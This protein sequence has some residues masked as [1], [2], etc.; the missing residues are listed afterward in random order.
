[1]STNDTFIC[2]RCRCEAPGYAR[3][4]QR[5]EFCFLCYETDEERKEREAIVEAH[6]SQFY[7]M[8]A[9]R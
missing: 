1:M 8:E 2:E 4:H 7:W 9:R 3:H 5:P 6:L